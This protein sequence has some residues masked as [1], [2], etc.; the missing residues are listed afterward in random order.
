VTD[1]IRHGIRTT[2]RVISPLQCIGFVAIT[3]YLF[4]FVLETLTVKMLSVQWDWVML[5]PFWYLLKQSDTFL[6]VST[7]EPNALVIW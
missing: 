5:H 6:S 2:Q 1:R 7:V 3:Y 4:P